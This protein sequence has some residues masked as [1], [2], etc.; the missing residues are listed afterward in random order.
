MGSISTF[1]F[2]RSLP[3]VSLSLDFVVVNLLGFFQEY[4]A[5]FVHRLATIVFLDLYGGFLGLFKSLF[6]FLKYLLRGRQL[7]LFLFDPV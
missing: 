3:I 2:E 1:D 7:G 5:G 6:L 4:R